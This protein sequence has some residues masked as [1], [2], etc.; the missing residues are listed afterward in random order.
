MFRILA[1]L[2]SLVNRLLCDGGRF[3]GGS[4]DP[5]NGAG[6]SLAALHA[7]ANRRAGGDGGVLVHGRRDD[8][9]CGGEEGEGFLRR[10]Y[11]EGEAAEEKRYAASAPFAAG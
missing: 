2:T 11:D 5:Q 1:H 7:S 9:Q 8:G 10:P 3:G 6:E 4:V